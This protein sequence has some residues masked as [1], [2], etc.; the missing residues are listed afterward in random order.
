[1]AT[2][3]VCFS[4]RGRSVPARS[5]NRSRISAGIGIGRAIVAMPVWTLPR[6]VSETRESYLPIML[7]KFRTSISSSMKRTSAASMECLLG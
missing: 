2:A 4:W 7:P 1:M 3:S 6:P 5:P